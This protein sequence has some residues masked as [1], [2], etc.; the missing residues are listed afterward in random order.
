M[1]ALPVLIVHLV[2]AAVSMQRVNKFL[3]NDELDDEAVQRDPGVYDQIQIRNGTFK[4]GDNDPLTL[5]DINF[6]VKPGSL[7]AVVGTVGSGKSSLL[8]ACLGEMVKVSGTVNVIGRTAYVPQQ[9]W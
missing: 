4:W 7:T 5:K 3:N 2:Q 8:G 1:N 6:F 9:A